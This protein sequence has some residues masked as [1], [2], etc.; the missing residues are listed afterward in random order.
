MATGIK[1]IVCTD[2]ITNKSQIL[3]V[4]GLEKTDLPSALGYFIMNALLESY[5]KA[6]RMP[7]A[8]T[9]NIMVADVD[10]SVIQANRNAVRQYKLTGAEYGEVFNLMRAVECGAQD[11]EN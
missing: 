7:V 4:E 1:C 10:P 2:E 5:R 9:L 8:P 3:V 6:R 11:E